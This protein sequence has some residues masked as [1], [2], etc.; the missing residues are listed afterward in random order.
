MADYSSMVWVE[1]TDWLAETFMK[2]VQRKTWLYDQEFDTI[3]G[4]LKISL[5]HSSLITEE[6]KSFWVYFFVPW[7]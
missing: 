5:I 3:V 1:K 4:L 6:M 2:W 7:A